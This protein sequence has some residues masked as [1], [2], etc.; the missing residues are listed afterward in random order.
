MTSGNN[1]QESLQC[2]SLNTSVKRVHVQCMSTDSPVVHVY[3][4]IW[5]GYN[6]RLFD[7]KTVDLQNVCYISL[8][9]CMYRR[10]GTLHMCIL[11]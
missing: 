1:G 4:C 6:S 9:M 2:D 7:P 5:C 3:H 8:Y 10:D 11:V